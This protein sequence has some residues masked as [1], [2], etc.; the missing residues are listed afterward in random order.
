MSHRH[1]WQTLPHH[2][3][4]H[5]T[6]TPLYDQTS[7]AIMNK[8]NQKKRCDVCIIGAGPAALATLSAIHEPYSLDS[9]TNTQVNNAQMT[10]T[11]YKGRGVGPSEKKICV[12]DPNDTWLSG[13]SDNFARYVIFYYVE[14]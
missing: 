14:L 13:W 8:P 1:C 11:R 3:P 7:K 4:I 2:N 9:M 12:V 6:T 5:Y 10:L